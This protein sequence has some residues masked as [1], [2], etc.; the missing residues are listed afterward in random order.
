MDNKKVQTSV[1]LWQFSLGQDLRLT[2]LLY[3]LRS[4][5]MTAAAGLLIGL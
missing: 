2:F 1:R 3:V 5:L 4:H